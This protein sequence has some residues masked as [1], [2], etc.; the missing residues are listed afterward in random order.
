MSRILLVLYPVCLNASSAG[1]G[2]RQTF[3]R[4]KCLPPSPC[5][6]VLATM[7]RNILLDEQ[8]VS[9]KQLF[10]PNAAPADDRRSAREEAS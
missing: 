5:F 6:Q 4:R 1:H 9:P 7:I 10:D 8:K 3:N 2:E